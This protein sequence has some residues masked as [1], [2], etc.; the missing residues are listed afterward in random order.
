MKLDSYGTRAR[1]APALLVG[2]PLALP[3]GALGVGD[4]PAWSFLWSLITYCGGSL[5]LAEF[6][7]D[8]GREKQANLFVSWGGTPTTRMLR[9]REA[10]NVVTLARYHQKIRELLP[11]QHIPTSEEEAR[12]PA[13]ADHVYADVTAFLRA[14]TRDREQ[15]SLLFEEN[16]TFGFRRNLWA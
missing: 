12:D 11:R 5:L 1:L 2:L 8:V 4:N 3:I 6:G 16:C 13:G 9:W 10:G 7:R 14:Q 15:F